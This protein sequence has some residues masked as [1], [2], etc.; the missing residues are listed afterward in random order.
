MALPL[1]TLPA[2]VFD[3]RTT[4]PL[5]AVDVPKLVRVPAVEKLRLAVAD[6]PPWL[7]G[8]AW[9][10][11]TGDCGLD[12]LTLSAVLEVEPSDGAFVLS[13]AGGVLEVAG[14]PWVIA[15]SGGAGTETVTW[16]YAPS[17]ALNCQTGVSHMPV[18]S[19]YVYS[20]GDFGVV[21]LV[22]GSQV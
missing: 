7:S 11:G 21:C 10:C 17:A 22:T 16:W 14:P 19:L 2:A 3:W 9:V 18:A 5:L 13:E 1:D 20:R 6:E 8:V 12:G 4:A 15:P